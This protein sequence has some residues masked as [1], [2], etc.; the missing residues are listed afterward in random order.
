MLGCCKASYI[1]PQ[2]L[3]RTR[4]QRNLAYSKSQ[5]AAHL[6]CAVEVHCHH[7]RILSMH[8]K[9]DDLCKTALGHNLTR[10]TAGSVGQLR[11]LS[12]GSSSRPGRTD[13]QQQQQQSVVP[14]IHPNM[15]E[16]EILAAAKA[17]TAPDTFKAG[18][19]LASG[20]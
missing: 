19:I 9:V 1:S 5:H 12:S 13:P 18:D 15:T 3:T 10:T 6:A 11:W 4:Q 17:A 14:G 16:A 20:R 7:L 2:E 8:D